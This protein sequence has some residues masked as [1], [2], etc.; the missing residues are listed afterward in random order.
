MADQFS[1][2]NWNVR[3]LN[4]PARREFVRDMVL[5]ANPKLVWLQETKLAM[6]ARDLFSETVGQRIDGFEFMWSCLQWVQE[7]E[8]Y[9]DGTLKS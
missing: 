8:S 9:W 3:G 6:I 4:S 1:I 2:F 5:S 7:V